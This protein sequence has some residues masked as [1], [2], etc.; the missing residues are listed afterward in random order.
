MTERER[1]EKTMKDCGYA[2][3]DFES[4]FRSGR[5]QQV[6]PDL[7]W[8]GWQ[9][10]RR[11]IPV[12]EDLPDES[13]PVWVYIPDIG[14]PVVMS[15]EE[16]GEGELAWCNAQHLF[17]YDKDLETWSCEP[18]FDDDYRPTHWQPLPEPP[19]AI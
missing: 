7:L 12:D 15:L 5:Y 11:W 17:W 9:A 2:A 14:Q 16:V 1:F 3:F 19:E 10:A 4:K 6:G 8:F 13:I 18:D